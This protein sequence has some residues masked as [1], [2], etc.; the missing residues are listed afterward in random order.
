T[1]SLLTLPQ[2]R[3]DLLPLLK[4]IANLVL[5]FSRWNRRTDTAQDRQLTYRTLQSNR[6]SQPADPGE[7]C[8]VA[9]LRFPR[10]GHDNQREIRPFRLVEQ[11]FDQPLLR[12]GGEEFLGKDRR[13][14]IRF[15]APAQLLRG[16]AA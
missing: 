11:C 4:F 1:V 16:R 12:I 9:A 7:K 5:P 2:R 8:P 6:M 15:H 3:L 14:G 10:R 13:N